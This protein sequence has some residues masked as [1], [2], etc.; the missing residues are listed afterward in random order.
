MTLLRSTD[1][2]AINMVPF[3]DMSAL[4]SRQSALLGTHLD[5]KLLNIFLW[6]TFHRLVGSPVSLT[7]R[8]TGG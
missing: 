3:R 6:L 5:V 1:T 4:L 7:L 8:N 2:N